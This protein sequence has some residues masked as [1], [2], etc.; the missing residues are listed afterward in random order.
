MGIPGA[1]PADLTGWLI[2]IEGPDGV[3]RTTHVDRL[4]AHLERLGY[5]VAA[6]LRRG[7]GR[8]TPVL[9]VLAVVLTL[10]GVFVGDVVGL[11]LAANAEGIPVTIADV[12]RVYPRIVSIDPG[13]ALIGYF[14]GAIGSSA[15]ALS[16]YRQMRGTSVPRTSRRGTVGMPGPVSHPSGFTVMVT[17]RSRTRAAARIFVPG[18]PAH[19][20]DASYDATFGSAVVALDGE[21]LSKARVWGYKKVVDVPIPGMSDHRLALR[22][23]GATAPRIDVTVDDTLLTTV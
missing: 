18:P 20:V 11:T 17:A 21:R 2:V 1:D 22:F 14:F 6:A 12:L 10:A 15:G 8:I 23:Y 9:I 16:L 5:A 13:R 3:G 7:A 19:T 4:R